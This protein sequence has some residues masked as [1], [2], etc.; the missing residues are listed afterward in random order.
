M[1]LDPC[2]STGNIPINVVIHWD[3]IGDLSTLPSGMTVHWYPAKGE[4]I[5]A[6]NMNVYGG[7]EWLY[8]DVYNAMCLDFNGNVNLAF[9][10]NGTYED[11]EVYNIRSTGTYNSFV[12]QLPGEVTVAEAYP[13]RLY[14]DSRKQTIDLEQP[15]SEDTVTVNFYPKDI[16][17][18]FSFLIYDVKGAEYITRNSGAISGMSG[19]YFPASGKLAASPSTILFSRVE[20]IKDGQNS[21]RWT[22]TEKA[23]FAAKN[24]NWNSSDTLTGWTRDWI[25]GKFVTFGPLNAKDHR[26]RLTVEAINTG[27]DYYYGAWENTVAGQID[28]AMGKKGTPEEQLAWRQRNGGYDIILF[29]DNR[30]TVDRS[31]NTGDGGFLVGIGDWGDIVNVPMPGSTARTGALRAAINTYT[32]IPDFVINGIHS[33]GGM[34]PS[35]VFNEQ[36][37]YKPESGLIWDYAPKKFWPSSGEIDFYAYAPAGIKHLTKGLY[38]NGGNLNV[39][40]IIGYSMPHKEREEPPPGTGERPSPLIV[41][42]DQED[43]LVAVQNRTS[44]QSNP[45]PINFRHAFSRVTVKAKTDKDY[46]NFNIKVTCVDL[47]NV[48]AAGKLELKP[49]GVGGSYSTGIPMEVGDHFRYNGNV[50]LWTD[51]DSLSNYRFR[52]ISGAVVIEDQYT[53]L[54]NSVDGI[55]VIPQAAGNAAVYVEYDIYS[56]LPTGGELYLDSRSKLQLLPVGFAFEIGRQYELQLTLDIP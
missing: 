14:I 44:P 37:V 54:L 7:R 26:F 4:N 5:I 27:N 17:R 42:D 32:T 16:L 11:F 2:P 38:N 39:P 8:T 18:E 36:Y 51:L 43:L 40:P 23:L 31:N 20:A 21:P 13:Y 47:R 25:T 22:D 30:L 10:S 28:S 49:D 56:V 52:L 46:G 50:T 53:A 1:D 3:S 9:R 29:N 12:P 35:L 19:S 41:D 48:Y 45:V 6:S 34:S 33:G 15:L 55:F 24:P